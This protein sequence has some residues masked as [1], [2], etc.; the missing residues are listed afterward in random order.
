MNFT[1]SHD[2]DISAQGYWDLFWSDDYNTDLYKQLNMRTRTVLEQKEEGNT[3]RRTQKLEPSLNVPSWANSVIKDTGYTEYDVYHRDRS[4]MEVR[5][6]PQMMKDRFHMHAV[7]KVIPLGENRCRR[8][9]AGEVK[10]SVPLLGGKLEKY[11]VDQLRD[12][13][14]VAARVTREWVQ[15][16]KAAT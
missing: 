16:R 13:Y 8:E 7:F 1:V 2:F 9:F 6:E 15:K 10:I 11:M 14:E 3:L 12:A 4:E 5:I